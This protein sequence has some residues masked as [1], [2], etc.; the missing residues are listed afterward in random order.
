MFR[1][2][3]QPALSAEW[4]GSLTCHC[5]NSGVE[6]T[7]NKSQH[8]KLTLEKKILLLLLPGFELTTF[9]SWDCLSYQ[10][11]INNAVQWKDGG[12][13]WREVLE[14][15]RGREKEKSLVLCLEAGHL[16]DE[17]RPTERTWTIL[18]GRMFQFLIV[19]GNS[20]ELL[21]FVRQVTSLC[22]VLFWLW[23][24]NEF[25]ASNNGLAIFFF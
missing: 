21:S 24:A 22:C 20:A 5:S 14:W 12:W 7:L 9:R 18:A 2:N 25:W 8:T 1:C 6:W 15:K 3:L 16:W 11:A 10:Q 23:V 19:L 17:G 13:G 4:P